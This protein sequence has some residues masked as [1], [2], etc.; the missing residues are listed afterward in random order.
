[1]KTLHLA[2]V[3]IL[4]IVF[5]SVIILPVS[6]SL[7]IFNSSKVQEII[8]PELTPYLADH[9]YAIVPSNTTEWFLWWTHYNDILNYSDIIFTGDVKSTNVLNV[10]S[11]YTVGNIASTL[12]SMEGTQYITGPPYKKINYT[13]NLDQYTVNIDEFLKNPQSSNNMTIREPIIDP[14]WHSDPLGPR[15]NVGDHVLFYV[16]NFDG[17][18]VYSQNSFIIPNACN[19]KDVF[20]QNRYASSDFTMTQ[21]GVQVDYDKSGNKPPFTANIPIQFMYSNRV[22]TLSGKDF[23]IKYDIVEDPSYRIVSSNKINISSK[24]CEWMESAKWELSLKSG[25]YYSNIYVKNDDGTFR[26][27]YSVGFSVKPNATNSL[28]SSSKLNSGE[29]PT[30]K[31]VP[32]FP[33]VMPILAISLISLLVFYRL[34]SSFKIRK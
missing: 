5:V 10:T 12:S 3:V 13:L 1:M 20:T 9:G 2:I 7:S 27:T 16:K 30:S 6:S 18:N 14:T 32:E 29:I 31:K 17:T 4:I 24:N 11:F 21:N 23:V 19:A 28:L 25:N 33:F 22:D 15:F 34:K 8:S 26:Q